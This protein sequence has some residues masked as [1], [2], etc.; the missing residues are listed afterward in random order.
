MLAG[1]HCCSNL[2][3][4]GVQRM[5]PYTSCSRGATLQLAHAGA[6]MPTLQVLSIAAALLQSIAAP[7]R[8]PAPRPLGPHPDD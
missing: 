7:A 5:P 3:A 8:N 4:K 1:E 2:P 6:A